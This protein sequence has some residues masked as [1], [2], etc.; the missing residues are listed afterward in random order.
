MHNNW[1]QALGNKM[2]DLYSAMIDNYSK[3]AL[4]SIGY[5]N[6]LKGGCSRRGPNNS[7]LRLWLAGQNA[8]PF[9]VAKLVDDVSSLVGLNTRFSHLEGKKVFELDNHKLDLLPR[10]ESGCHRHNCVDYSISKLSKRASP[11]QCRSAMS[12]PRVA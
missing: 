5:Y 6:F 9:R 4:Q 10:D 2:V 1:L 8:N 12:I 3:A 11:S 7:V